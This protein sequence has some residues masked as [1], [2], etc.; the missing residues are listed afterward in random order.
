MVADVT[1]GYSK[2]LLKAFIDG[3][4]SRVTNCLSQPKQGKPPS[5][6]WDLW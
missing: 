5:S 1:Y 2:K 3:D 6:W 4:K